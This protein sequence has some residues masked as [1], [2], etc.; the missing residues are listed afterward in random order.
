[1][2]RLLLLM[3]SRRGHPRYG[4]VRYWLAPGQLGQPALALPSVSNCHAS[5]LSPSQHDVL[6]VKTEKPESFAQTTGRQV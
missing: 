1:M 6:G 5:S 2:L 4:A 3:I